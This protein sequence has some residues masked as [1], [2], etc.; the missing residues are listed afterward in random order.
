MNRNN[1]LNELN[2]LNT[3][4][5]IDDIKGKEFKNY[6]IPI[7]EGEF[8]IEI[9]FKINID[10]CSY[11]FADCNKI[12]NINFN[13]FKTRNVTNMSYMFYNCESLKN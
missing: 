13:S 1:N 4:I 6:F 3:E 11:M 9:K 8:N 2:I 10:D 5:Y 12:I 7:K